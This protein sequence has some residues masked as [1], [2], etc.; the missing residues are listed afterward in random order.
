MP[1]RCY[2]CPQGTT[3]FDPVEGGRIINISFDENAGSNNG[4]H[5]V[6]FSPVPA[7]VAGQYFSPLAGCYTDNTNPQ[8]KSFNI[9]VPV[10]EGQTIFLTAGTCPYTTVTIRS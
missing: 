1:T 8:F 4:F 3:Q 6:Q 2:V 10:A 9:D 7:S 5:S